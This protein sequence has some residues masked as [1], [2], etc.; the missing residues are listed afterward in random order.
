[1]GRRPA[2]RPRGGREGGQKGGFKAA[3]EAEVVHEIEAMIAPGAVDRHKP[4][5][6]EASGTDELATQQRLTRLSG[7]SVDDISP[8]LSRG[9]ARPGLVPAVAQRSS[10][11]WVA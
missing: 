5:A 8:V 3:F 9:W 4:R 2:R 11:G 7:R 1:M 6:A 10:S